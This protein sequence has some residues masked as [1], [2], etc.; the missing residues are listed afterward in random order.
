[1]I[2]DICEDIDKIIRTGNA[3]KL[4]ELCNKFAIVETAPSE[5]TPDEQ[6]ATLEAYDRF[7]R[8]FESIKTIKTR[9]IRFGSIGIIP[10]HELMN[11]TLKM[12]HHRVGL[13]K[14]Y[15]VYLGDLEILARSYYLSERAIKKGLQ[16]CKEN[17]FIIEDPQD[18]YRLNV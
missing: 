8:R 16:L 6:L 1:M 12:I 15:K 5:M 10:E 18:W 9:C 4:E 17:S 7:W 13:V 11:A 14:D 2:R 3:E